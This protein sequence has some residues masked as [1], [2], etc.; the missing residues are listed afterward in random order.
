M[1]LKTLTKTD[2]PLIFL[3]FQRRA[4][5]VGLVSD[6]RSF[7]VVSES[8]QFFLPSIAESVFITIQR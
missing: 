3:H 4:T 7:E 6:D 8:H 5:G 2:S 1:L